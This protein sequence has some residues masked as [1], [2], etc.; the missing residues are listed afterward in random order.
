MQ[1]HLL[2]INQDLTRDDFL[3]RCL[4]GHTQNA[5]ESFKATIWRLSQKH[6]HSGL[7]IIAI[8]ACLAAG[9]FNEGYSS[10][11]QIVNKL[12]LTID[13]YAKVFAENC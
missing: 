2:L 4:S 7:K 10:A 9:I 13:I 3:E 1:E 8:S 6:I 12:N 11:L 5:N